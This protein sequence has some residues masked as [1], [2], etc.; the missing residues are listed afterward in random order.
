[1]GKL[2]IYQEDQPDV[3]LFHSGSP[4]DIA[5]QLKAVGVRFETWTPKFELPKDADETAVMQAYGQDIERLI[6]QEG[7]QSVDVIR[8][9]PDNE[10]K[11]EL[12][13]KFLNEHTHSEDEVRFFVEG[14]GIFYLHVLEKVYV[15]LCE[16]GDFISVPAQ[17]KHWFDMGSSPHFTA[18]RLFISP[19]GWVANFTGEKI[20]EI[21][22]KYD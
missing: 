6:A 17:T 9:F 15:V 18:I 5:E 11:V 1:M 22:P 10:K 16:A 19:D 21:F 14:A 2:T 20:S 13:Q 12:R 3:I 8:M 7:Y 4:Q